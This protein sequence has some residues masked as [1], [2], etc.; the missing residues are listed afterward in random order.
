MAAAIHDD[1]EAIDV[2]GHGGRDE[3]EVPRLRGGAD[4]ERLPAGERRGFGEFAQPA[5][6]AE[7]RLAPEIGGDLRRRERGGV[8][9]V[10]KLHAHAQRLARIET[11]A[12]EGNGEHARLARLGRGGVHDDAAAREAA[13]IAGKFHGRVAVAIAHGDVRAVARAVG[14]VGAGGRAFRGHGEFQIS[15]GTGDEDL[16]VCAANRH[17]HGGFRQHERE[18]IFH[19]HAAV[20]RGLARFIQHR[21]TVGGEVKTAV[22]RRDA[23]GRGG[24]VREEVKRESLEGRGGGEDL[25][26]GQQFLRTPIKT[27]RNGQSPHLGGQ[28]ANRAAVHGHD[29]DGMQQHVE[30]AALRAEARVLRG[31]LRAADGELVRA[32]F[33]DVLAVREVERERVGAAEKAALI[34]ALERVFAVDD[35]G[36]HVVRVVVELGLGFDFGVLRRE[37]GGR[38]GA[39][40]WGGGGIGFRGLGSEV[41]FGNGGGDE[42]PG[43]VG[44]DEAEGDFGGAG[45]GGEE[46]EKRDSEKGEKR[47]RCAEGEWGRAAGAAVPPHPGPLPRGEGECFGRD[48][49]F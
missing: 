28:R 35:D 30:R 32:R 49:Q 43:R 26:L 31:D 25:F 10:L 39:R 48:R 12:R 9:G 22:G 47:G 38:A 19:E 11:V 29:R 6:V 20:G 37:V 17:G 46:G 23:V 13:E 2:A 5:V 8:E 14:E 21:E 45:V 42:L 3:I 36:P 16:H 34:G 40:G 33:D 4:G 24:V 44:A 18:A 15:R 41:D 1:A 7:Q 27:G